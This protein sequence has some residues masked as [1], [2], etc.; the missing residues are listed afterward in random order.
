MVF[1]SIGWV[2]LKKELEKM[3]QKSKDKRER[4]R[5]RTHRTT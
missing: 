5:K 1:P 3:I 4:K 2:F